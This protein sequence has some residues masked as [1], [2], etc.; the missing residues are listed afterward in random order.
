MSE[1][2]NRELIRTELT[3]R[4]NV[5][6]AYAGTT[7]DNEF[8]AEFSACGNAVSMKGLCEHYFKVFLLEHARKYHSYELVDNSEELCGDTRFDTVP[9]LVHSLMHTFNSCVLVLH[10]PV[11]AADDSPQDY[12]A[13]YLLGDSR[14]VSHCWTF[15]LS[16]T[17]A[18]F[19]K[20][21]NL[22]LG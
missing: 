16:N 4:N 5:W 20:T 10:I 8:K 12:K 9:V 6:I 3:K 21:I 7:A 11:L 15:L 14:S 22:P 17:L 19:H 1:V 18:W 13:L 2:A